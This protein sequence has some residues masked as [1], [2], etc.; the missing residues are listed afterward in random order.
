[1]PPTTLRSV[2]RVRTATPD[3][4][5]KQLASHLGRRIPTNQDTDGSHRLTFE[6]GT[7]VL[8][9]GDGVL[10]MTVSSP[11]RA[12]LEQVQDVLARH[13]IRFGERQQLA[14]AFTA[15]PEG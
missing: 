7:A 12:G 15:E 13:L 14:V 4:Y 5:A 8:Q 3:R 2:A 1:M 11:T 9:S 6:A 10:V